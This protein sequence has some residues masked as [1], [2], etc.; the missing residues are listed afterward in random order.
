MRCKCALTLLCYL[1]GKTHKRAGGRA[2]L[3]GTTL[4]PSITLYKS[5]ARKRPAPSRQPRRG[6]SLAKYSAP[7]A[8][9][10]ITTI[11]STARSYPC[12]SPASQARARATATSAATRCSTALKK[13]VRASI[14]RYARADAA[15]IQKKQSLWPARSWKANRAY[16]VRKPKQ[17][18]QQQ[19]KMVST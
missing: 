12:P 4:T 9:S 8:Q 11:L 13:V 18:L 17:P 19:Q 1:T 7:L 5:R 15:S 6:R 3:S 2:I 16:I 10:L 14:S